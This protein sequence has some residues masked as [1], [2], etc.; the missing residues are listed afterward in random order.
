VSVLGKL[1]LVRGIASK[2]TK[3]PAAAFAD[4]VFT[5]KDPSYRALDLKVDVARMQ[6]NIDDIHRI[7]ALPATIDA[8]KYIDMSLAEDAAKRLGG[9]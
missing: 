8:A 2:V 9:S 5:R 3:Q 4:W 1:P 6:K 7:G